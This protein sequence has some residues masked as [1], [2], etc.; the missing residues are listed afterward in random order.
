MWHI[1]FPRTWWWTHSC[2]ANSQRLWVRPCQNS[3]RGTVPRWWFA[4]ATGVVFGR[5]TG[6]DGLR[7]LSAEYSI[8]CVAQKTDSKKYRSKKYLICR[9]D[10]FLAFNFLPFTVI[11]YIWCVLYDN[12]LYGSVW[13]GS[14][15]SVMCSIVMLIVTYSHNENCQIFVWQSRCMHSHSPTLRKVWNTIVL[16][17]T[18]WSRLC[19]FTFCV[20]EC[21]VRRF[22]NVS[23]HF[24]GI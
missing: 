1:L 10:F 6:I 18:I 22:Q 12:V 13:Y 21:K 23:E 16:S 8:F 9:K 3:Q 24:C 19:N 17:I 14:V 15:L 4:K 7:D 11:N 20:A 2:H 5:P